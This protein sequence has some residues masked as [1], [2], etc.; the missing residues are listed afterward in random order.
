MNKA[1]SKTLHSYDYSIFTEESSRQD[2][3]NTPRSSGYVEFG[4]IQG[5]FHDSDFKKR[6][7]EMVTNLQ[8]IAK[9]EGL[10]ESGKGAEALTPKIAIINPSRS[11]LD[12]KR[13]FSTRAQPKTGNI[14]LNLR[15]TKLFVIIV[16]SLS[17]LLVGSVVR[18][19]ILSSNMKDSYLL[20]KL[21]SLSINLYID[22]IESNLA[23]ADTVL[24]DNNVSFRG[25]STYDMFYIKKNHFMEEVLKPLKNL[26]E[27]GNRLP[28]TMYREML[29]TPFCDVIFSTSK[30]RYPNCDTVMSGIAIKPLGQFL[31]Y[32]FNLL[33]QLLS[34]WKLLK[35]L[36]SRHALLR[37]D[38]YI[39]IF[40]YATFDVYG[41]ADSIYYFLIVKTFSLL[42]KNLK[43]LPNLISLMNIIY[44]IWTSIVVIISL[45]TVS[46]RVYQMQDLHWKVYQCIPLNLLNSNSHIK[47]WIRK[48]TGQRIDNY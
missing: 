32:Y 48:T 24:W 26:A 45:I 4:F 28:H 1:L 41:T 16:I 27:S 47:E 11:N 43:D 25:R 46:L 23:V 36:P 40:A 13:N 33:D 15:Q 12:K 35:D 31:S 21:A 3:K 20:C 14:K 8:Q 19:F 10:Y 39:G 42:T 29:N 7:S 9:E 5:K 44:G 17:S 34:E 30:T 22:I 6:R 18:Y 2:S 38:E 37:R